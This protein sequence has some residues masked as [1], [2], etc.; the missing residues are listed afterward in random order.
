MAENQNFDA[1]YQKKAKK[2]NI[3]EKVRVSDIFQKTK[4]VQNN[5]PHPV[6]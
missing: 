1:I 2:S 3:S 4:N 5:F 6:N